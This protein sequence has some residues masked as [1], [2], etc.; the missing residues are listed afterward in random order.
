MQKLFGDQLREER[1][2][3]DLTA[4]MIA[5]ACGISRSYITL[6]ES[7]KRQPGKRILPKIAVALHLN[8]SVVLDW[9]LVNIRLSLVEGN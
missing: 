9:Y 1:K 6:I 8:K 2:K 4:E 7:G 5:K 3:Q